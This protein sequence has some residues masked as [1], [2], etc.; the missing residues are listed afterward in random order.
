MKLSVT[1]L[2]VLLSAA[3]SISCTND[4]PDGVLDK[5]EMQQVLY[6]YHLAKA[7]DEANRETTSQQGKAQTAAVNAVLQKYGITQAQ[8]IES[9][10]W[11]SAHPEILFDI[12]KKIEA[13]LPTAGTS[14]S[15][16]HSQIAAA[17]DTLVI[18]AGAPFNILSNAYNPFMTVSATKLDKKGVKEGSRYVLDYTTEWY[19]REGSRNATFAIVVT[20]ANDST[21]YVTY[22]SYGSGPQSVELPQRPSRPRSIEGFVCIAGT[23]SQ[24][25]QVLNLISPT[26]RAISPTRS[27]TGDTTMP[28]E[29]QQPDSDNSASTRT[30]AERLLRDSLLHIDSVQKHRPHFRN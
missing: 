20:Y 10:H 7:I 14:L 4:M 23:W 26:L 19:V 17:A 28:T 30:R 18:W 21:D 27:T 22:N 12:Y 11:Y 13:E 1:L 5:E 15:A 24:R 6:D 16:S 25:P 29:A 9:M 8:F 2:S 3:L